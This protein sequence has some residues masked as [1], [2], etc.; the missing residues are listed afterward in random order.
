MKRADILKKC[1]GEK[2]FTGMLEDNENK[3]IY[4]EK[5]SEKIGESLRDESVCE[6]G[7]C[8]ELKNGV[9]NEKSGESG[10]NEKSGEK[11]ERKFY[12]QRDKNFAKKSA[13]KNALVF[14]VIGLLLGPF[15][16]I[17]IVPSAAGL[18]MAL[19]VNRKSVTKTWAAVISAIGVVINAAFI[20]ALIVTLNVYGVVLP[21]LE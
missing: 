17:G 13:A 14:A 8:E 1:K 21:N 20:A 11:T 5:P 3:G 18:V 15:F 16:G 10:Y 4:E 2:D 19:N 7:F 6:S 9:H 12:Y